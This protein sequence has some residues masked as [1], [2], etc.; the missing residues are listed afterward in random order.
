MMDDLMMGKRK[1]KNG[2]LGR[3]DRDF[4]LGLPKFFFT[5]G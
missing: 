3:S 1:M 2:M 5:H 4:C